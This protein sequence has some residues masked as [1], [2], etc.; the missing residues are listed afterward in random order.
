MTR[1]AAIILTYNEAFHIQAC[2]A[3]A[4][5]ADLV[6]VFDSYSSDNTV[7]LAHSAGAEVIQR[8]FDDY[9]RQRNAALE[10]VKDRAD[11]AL[12]VDADER[13]D[14][15]LAQEICEVV[16]NQD[17]VAWQIPRNNYIAGKLTKWGGWYPD[18]QTRLLRIGYANYDPTRKVHEVVQINGNLGTLKN[19][20]T[21]FNYQNMRQFVNKQRKYTAYE[22]QILFDQGIRPKPQNYVL[23]PI[24]HFYWRYITLGGYRMGWHGLRLCLVMAW[25]ELRKYMKLRELWRS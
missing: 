6:V 17:Y 3:S 18:Y 20:L 21:H 8:E 15:A 16:Q 5:F 13:V 12:F 9:A 11:C 7:S 2:I 1:L 10:T 22:A 4:Q 24:R 25:Y 19:E 23:Q 14:D